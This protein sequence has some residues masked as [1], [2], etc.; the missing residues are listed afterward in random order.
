MFKKL[1]CLTAIVLVFGLSAA[2]SYGQFDTYD[3]D[4]GGDGTS[5]SDPN[6][7]EHVSDP[8]GAP[9]GGNPAAPP[10]P[11]T[12][13]NV[14]ILGVVIDPNSTA[15]DVFVG[16]AAGSRI[17]LKCAPL[18]LWMTFSIRSST[19]RTTSTSKVVPTASR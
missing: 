8:N 14:P 12:I 2:V 6:N 4:G 19:I 15:K 1:L 9:V 13:S 5:W 10:A 17:T 16:R 3:F 7:W 18:R 11:T